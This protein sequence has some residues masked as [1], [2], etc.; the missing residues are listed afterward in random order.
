M[1]LMYSTAK[2]Y[3][4]SREAREANNLIE[5]EIK[6]LETKKVQL[7]ASVKRLQTESGAEEAIRDKFPV[8]KPGEQTVIIIEEENKNITST[9]TSSSSLPLKIWQFLENLF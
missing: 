2:I 6:S 9:S 4:R 7:E 3:I 5:E 8:R 1:F